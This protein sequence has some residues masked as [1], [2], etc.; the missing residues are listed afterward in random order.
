MAVIGRKIL[1]GLGDV[2]M[3]GRLNTD[4]DTAKIKFC[5]TLGVVGEGARECEI[6]HK[7]DNP[8]IELIFDFESGLVLFE[9]LGLALKRLELQKL[10]KQTTAV[11]E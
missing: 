5:D 11:N 4:G 3:L 9:M 1:L 10:A 8:P 6:D 2:A 7:S